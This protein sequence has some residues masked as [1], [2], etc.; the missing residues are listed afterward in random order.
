MKKTLGL[1]AETADC[2]SDG[3]IVERKIRSGSQWG[4][5]PVQVWYV[6]VCGGG[7]SRERHQGKMGERNVHQ[8]MTKT[9]G[10]ET[11][12]VCV[13]TIQFIFFLH[14]NLLCTNTHFVKVEPLRMHPLKIST[15]Q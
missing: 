7:V 14:T 8:N 6:C 13:H 11:F 4:L 5:L 10:W 1:L 12:V 15:L 3:D 9:R 2:L